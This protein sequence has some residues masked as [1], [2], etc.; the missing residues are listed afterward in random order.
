[1]LGK[2]EE[3]EEE[4]EKS[5]FSRN[6]DDD[7]NSSNITMEHGRMLLSRLERVEM[8]TCKRLRPNDLA[9]VSALL[10]IMYR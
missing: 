5:K 1:M 10:Y 2:E 6:D 7:S 9:D 3:K 8:K 4:E